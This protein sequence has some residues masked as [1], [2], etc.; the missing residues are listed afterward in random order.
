MVKKNHIYNK[1]KSYILHYANIKYPL[2]RK[3]KYSLEY[4]L[5]KFTLILTDI[6]CWESLEN[7]YNNSNKYHWKSIYNEFNKWSTDGIFKDAYFK[8]MK[9]NY[10]KMSKVKKNK[11]IN[12][13]IDVT[14]ISNKAGSEN[15]GI[16][17]EYKKKNA[18]SL[19]VICDDNKLPLSTVPVKTN[20]YKTK[21]SKHTIS[22]DITSVQRTLDQIPFDLPKSVLVNIIGD[23]G[24]V[25]SKKYNVFDKKINITHPK[26]KNQKVQNTKKENKVLAKRHKIENFFAMLKKYNR[27][28]IRSERK[29]MH[30][31]SFIYIGLLYILTK[32]QIRQQTIKNI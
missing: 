7:T 22:H 12:L 11:K 26:R 10:F 18:R 25:S 4:Y 1:Y 20:L 13:F 29:I 27:I 17:S 23:K 6:V 2:V 31:M 16:N 19:S 21:T 24:Y 14:K 5:N 28:V 15:I 32:A 9:E 3:R 30:Y 8:F